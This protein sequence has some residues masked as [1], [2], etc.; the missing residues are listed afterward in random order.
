MMA[1]PAGEKVWIGGGVT[2]M[3]CGV[4]SLALKVQQ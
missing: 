4:N 1:F 3:R 2:D